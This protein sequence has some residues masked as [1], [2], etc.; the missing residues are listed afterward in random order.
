MSENITKDIELF[1]H[2]EEL[3]E[4]AAALAKAQVVMKPAIKAT[5]NTFFKSSYADIG[6][7]LEVASEL[8]KNGIAIIQMPAVYGEK[9]FCETKLVHTSGQ[10][11]RG[12]YPINPVK[13]DPQGIGSA[14]TYARRYSLVG[15]AGI[16]T[17]DD[18]GNAAS[19]NENQTETKGNVSKGAST[20]KTKGGASQSQIDQVYKVA[21][22]LGMGAADVMDYCGETFALGLEELS[23]AQCTQL[24]LN[25]RKMVKDHA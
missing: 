23:T 18:D 9:F 19:G 20:E 14:Y 16:R 12:L 7:V 3:G 25:L 2:S 1:Q 21:E 8:P 6:A 15:M 22:T 10:W 5:K 13:N 24:I 11:I 17:E 4:L